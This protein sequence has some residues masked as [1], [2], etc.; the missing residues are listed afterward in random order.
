MPSSKK[1]AGVNSDTLTGDQID[2]A[3][4]T[5]ADLVL[6]EDRDALMSLAASII[7]RG[8]Q[9]ELAEWAG[10]IN[11]GPERAAFLHTLAATKDHED[12][13]QRLAL[14]AA[15]SIRLKGS[16]D[17]ATITIATFIS[18]GA[19]NDLLKNKISKTKVPE[20]VRYILEGMIGEN[21]EGMFGEVGLAARGERVATLFGY[22]YAGLLNRDLKK[23]IINDK[24]GKGV[25]RRSEETRA[26]IRFLLADV[27]RSDG[28]STYDISIT[29][30]FNQAA[31]SAGQRVDVAY[32]NDEENTIVVGEALTD[33]DASKQS[34]AMHKHIGA[35]IE[36][37]ATPGSPLFGWDV[38]PFYL[39]SGAFVP[40]DKRGR[41][42]HKTSTTMNMA[43]VAVGDQSKLATLPL[44]SVA[45][46]AN[47]PEQVK[48]FF[49]CNH[50]VGGMSTFAHLRH[51]ERTAHM[52]PEQALNEHVKF[53]SNEVNGAIRAVSAIPVAQGTLGIV[54]SSI[55]TIS[56]FLE[57]SSGPFGGMN[58][59]TYDVY[60]EPMLRLI[61]E[62]CDKVI[63]THAAGSGGEASRTNM[64]PWLN[65]MW[66]AE[67]QR[68]S[69]YDSLH[70]KH[71]MSNRILGS[72]AVRAGTV[73]MN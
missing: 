71:S 57:D 12:E 24:D 61:E 1:T 7:A 32:F 15:R 36:A 64:D 35:L 6:S 20:G 21:L 14:M 47:S 19:G 70:A 52:N 25:I 69:G 58:Q 66:K 26:D 17:A 63:K 37:T 44:M 29:R 68:K 56:D 10:D 3:M 27:I 30:D 9:R 22:A 5:M 54:E 43:G 39:H 45:M 11:I 4:I 23:G 51:V 72:D 59:E 46:L 34:G 67:A 28:S 49:L 73:S 65:L 18:S 48:T 40:G 41:A 55:K 31:I 33:K 38:I 53:L 42:G 2:Q 62:K 50:L 13:L 8:G 60:W 16:S